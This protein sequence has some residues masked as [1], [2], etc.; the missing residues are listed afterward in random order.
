[1][2]FKEMPYV[3]P[4]ADSVKKELAG[5]TEALKKAADY[6]EAR[7]VFLAEYAFEKHFST[8]E[9][10]ERHRSSRQ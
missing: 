3:R 10:N 4:D 7:D 1:M 5:F 9:K 6:K 2:K 8:E